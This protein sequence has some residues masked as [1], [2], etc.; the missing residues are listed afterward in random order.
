M[1][2]SSGDMGTP[3]RVA[4]IGCV[5]LLGEIIG[6]TLAAEPD[7]DVVADYEALSY[8]DELSLATADLVVWNNA[9]ESLVARWLSTLSNRCG[10]RVLATMGDGR[11]A[12]LWELTP[13]RKA[14]GAL[15][16]T[17]LVDTIRSSLTD[18]AG[19]IR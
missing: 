14:L 12:S 3:L 2:G 9:D 19:D 5:G 11:E 7:L 4:L 15:S 16:P 10:P 18:V 1:D 8:D 6:R 17:T 13:Q